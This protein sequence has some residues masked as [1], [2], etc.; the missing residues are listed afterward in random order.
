MKLDILYT[1]GVFHSLE[2]PGETFGYLGVYKGR[3]TWLSQERPAHAHIKKEISLQGMHAYPGLIDTHIHLLY[4]LV[5]AASSFTICQVQEGSIQP[6]CLQGVQALL[7]KE[8]QKYGPE[9]III[10]NGYVMSAIWEHRLPTRQELDAWTDN[11]KVIVYN[12]DGHSSSLSTAMMQAVGLDCQGHD[13]ILCGPEH[14]FNQGKITDCIAKG[15]TPARLAKG[16]GNFT[17]NCMD[18]GISHVCAMDGNGDVEKDTLTLLLAQIA[19]RMQIG[20][21]LY[22]QYKDVEKARP[23]FRYMGRPRLGGCGEWEMDGS[24]SSQSAAFYQPYQSGQQGRCYYTDEELTCMVQSAR[25]AGCQLAVHA[26]GDAAIDQIQ[27]KLLQL[28]DPATMHRIEHF[29]FPSA[30]AVENM[31][32]SNLAITVQPGFA[33]MDKRYL[34]GYQQYL[35]AEVICQQVPL[36]QLIQAGVCV[37]GS[38]DSPVQSMNPFQ[39]M[40]GMV[41]FY[42]EEQSITPYEALCTYTKNAAKMLG[43]QEDLGTLAVGKLANFFTLEKDMLTLDP[44]QWPELRAERLVVEGR[45]LQKKK[46][47]QGELLGLLFTPPHLI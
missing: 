7:Q 40:L 23:L 12:L 26:I 36:R 10:A 11:R 17:N 38:S 43:E 35:S 8:A 21:R 16:I 19:R 30:Q 44:Q 29:E 1:Q 25:E 47:G 41:D 45:A 6:D 9:E 15:I 28:E 34:K 3:I 39:Q 37:C 24:V 20:V 27:Q 22:P 14:E 2:Q 42:V 4:S 31:C 18:F 33:W 5:L 13:G 32:G 46:G